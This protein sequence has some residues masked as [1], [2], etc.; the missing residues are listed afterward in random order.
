MC[1]LERGVVEVL[2]CFLNLGELV[3]LYDR[4]FIRN[5]DIE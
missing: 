3:N 5:C 4:K 1:F 2:I